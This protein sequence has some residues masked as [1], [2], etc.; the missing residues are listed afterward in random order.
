MKKVILNLAALTFLCS[1]MLSCGSKNEASAN[2]SDEATNSAKAS[3]SAN[4]TQM[5]ES[6]ID[7]E[8]SEKN[9]SDTKKIEELINQYEEGVKRKASLINNPPMNPDAAMRDLDAIDAELNGIAGKLNGMTLSDEQ[10]TRFN[11]AKRKN[12][13][14]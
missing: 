5:E 3:A 11:T 14:S 6:Q 13:N 12:K 10:K 2:A 4:A 8:K 7:D 9:A 1:I